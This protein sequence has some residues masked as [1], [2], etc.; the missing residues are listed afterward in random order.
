MGANVLFSYTW[1]RSEFQ[2]I[3]SKYIPTAWDN[4]HLFNLTATRSFKKNWDIGFKYRFTGG[5]PFTPDDVE[6]SSN[7]LAWNAQSRAYPNYNRFN[8]ERLG[9]YNQFDVR[10]DKS[11]Y[12]DTW[13]L[14]LYLDIQNLFG[15]S[16]DTPDILTVDTDDNGQRIIVN[17]DAPIN[18]QQYQMRY[19]K[20]EGSGTILP[21]VGIMIEF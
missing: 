6:K 11:F 1:V 10:V 13:S 15:A 19:I 14:M 4:K 16:V 17:P 3:N 8:Q 21:T 12:F 18:E 5:A 20:T 2:D 9:M 7:V